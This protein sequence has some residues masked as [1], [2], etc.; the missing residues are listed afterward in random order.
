MSARMQLLE[1][2]YL[3]SLLLPFILLFVYSCFRFVCYCF[4]NSILLFS[5]TTAYVLYKKY[6][7]YPRLNLPLLGINKLSPIQFLIVLI[8]SGLTCACNLLWVKTA[9]QAASRAAKL[10]LIN[11]LPLYLAGGHEFGAR[12]LFI[13]LETYGIFH[14]TA[15]WMASIECAIH[16]I[17]IYAKHGD[18][19]TDDSGFY[20]IVGGSMILALLVLPMVKRRVYEVFLV[21]HLACAFVGLYAIWKHLHFQKSSSVRLIWV[22]LSTFV[23]T[24]SLQLCRI[25]YR[26]VHTRR[27]A[28]IVC[29]F[30]G[31]EV[32]RVA[33]HMPRPWAVR[34]GERV[35]LGIPGLG[36]FYIFQAHPFSVAWWESDTANGSSP[37]YLMFRVRNGFTRKIRGCLNPGQEYRAW[38]DGPFGP[39]SSVP[40]DMSLYGHILMAT[41]GIGIAAQ[42]PYI[43]EILHR[44]RA[45]EACTE[46]ISL[47]WE[48]DRSGDYSSAVEWLQELIS[49]DQS[50]I[51][52][53]EIYTG[54]NM[55]TEKSVAL[56][57]HDLI[58]IHAGSIDWEG[59]VQDESN[60]Q[61][62]RQL[63]AAEETLGLSV[64]P[65]NVRL[66]AEDGIQYAWHVDDIS[67]RH[68][69]DKHLS[70]H[71]VGA[72]QRLCSEVGQSFW[73]IYNEPTKKEDLARSEE[74]EHLEQEKK[75]LVEKLAEANT[76][77]AELLD[78][79]ESVEAQRDS[80]EESI[81]KSNQTLLL[82]Q[83]EAQR[84]MTI[85]DYYQNSFLYVSDALA[86]VVTYLQGVEGN[87]Y[88][89]GTS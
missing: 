45:A 57:D 83:E 3:T 69:F 17:I 65:G 42:I 59:K 79:I 53:I 89:L 33:I 31:D 38:V 36:I 21:T 76:K 78:K 7:I 84:W 48:L 82:H 47:I 81:S 20:G 68:L 87:S 13:P 14:R 18:Q 6:L 61:K 52:N 2:V 5:S 70:K 29:S 74:I 12:L 27:S 49:Q 1:T 73:A 50:Y 37:I 35:N 26:N 19:G 55:I 51:L 66:K 88:T 40:N 46:R 41:S 77:I 22:C 62:G 25:L 44:R 8:Y 72:Y 67:L 75:I 39:S 54:V 86:H 24:S 85:S 80:L 30:I 16:I 11:L 58:K 60:R 32:I 4:H 56:G 15:G 28:R 43:K 63:V 23:V 64:K 71:S 9:D 10:S 34:A